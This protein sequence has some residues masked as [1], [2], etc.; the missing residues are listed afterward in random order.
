MKMML[1]QI[2]S[3]DMYLYLLP[4]SIRNIES[5]IN[6]NDTKV[7]LKKYGYSIN[8]LYCSMLNVVNIL[9]NFFII[10]L[11]II[12]DKEYSYSHKYDFSIAAF[13]RMSFKYFGFH[14]FYDYT[15]F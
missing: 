3:N 9:Y 7:K 14:Q 13:T 6:N 15:I 2:A 8:E 4:S 1:S 11:F 5:E 12:I 10:L